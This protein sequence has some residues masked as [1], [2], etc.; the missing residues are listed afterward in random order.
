[1]VKVALIGNMNNNFFT[2]LRYLQDKGVNSDLFLYNNE[3]EHFHPSCDS[4]SLDYMDHCKRLN[5]GAAHSF[6]KTASQNILTDLREYDVTIGCGLAPAYLNKAGLSLDIFKPYGGDIWSETFFRL[7]SPHRLPSIWHAVINQRKGI[8]K[9]VIF[10]MPVTNATYEE[11][12]QRY[13]GN[14]LR[15]TEGM[16]MVYAPIYSP[17]TIQQH[18][19]KTHWWA[20][21]A[22]VRSSC[23][24]MVFSHARHVHFTENLSLI[25]A[26]KG[27]EKLLEGWALFLKRNPKIRAKLITLEY[28]QDVLASRRL[29]KELNIQDSVIW[30]PKMYRKDLMVGL[31]YSDIVCG[32]FTNSWMTGGVLYEA[33]VS[34]KPIL[35]YRDDQLYKDYYPNIYPIMNAN[36][37]VSIADR[38]EEYTSSPDTF[39][40]MGQVGARW[41]Q[42]EVVEKALTKYLEYIHAKR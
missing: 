34:R 37:P 4:F 35:A 12:W 27:T 29:I 26:V 36:D 19:K 14:S 16:P 15:W 21:F 11:Q 9:S 30:F 25:P 8:P 10:H 1:M 23:D 42:E 40:E 2:L 33:L 24:L 18:L 22:K 31:F 39:K 3:L 5:W 41:Y 6:I 32:E 17:D 28:G 7:A 38:L 13:R 20:A